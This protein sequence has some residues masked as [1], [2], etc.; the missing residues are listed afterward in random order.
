MEVERVGVTGR[1]CSLLPSHARTRCSG[2]RRSATQ[3]R[4]SPAARV[5]RLVACTGLQ[6]GVGQAGRLQFVLLVAVALVLVVVGGAS[7][8]TWSLAS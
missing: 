7:H 4:A 2:T 8:A 1:G 3:P 6:G 5:G